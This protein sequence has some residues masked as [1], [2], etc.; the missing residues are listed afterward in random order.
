MQLFASNTVDTLLHLDF[1]RVRML[2]HYHCWH[3]NPLRDK[4]LC[5]ILSFAPGTCK[6]LQTL[7]EF[8]RLRKLIAWVFIFR[9]S[10]R[11]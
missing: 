7:L 1:Q 4:I 5:M 3:G 10:A 2:C 11:T 9:V 8:L 6:S